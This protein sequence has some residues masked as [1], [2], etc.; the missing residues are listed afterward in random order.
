M[1][2]FEVP[3]PILNPPFEE[4]A[5]HWYIQEGQ[6]P[7][8]RPGRRPSIVFPPEEQNVP[9]DLADGTLAASHEYPGG[10]EL[11]LVNRVR[12]RLKTWREQGYPGATRT[13]LHLL[14]WWCRDGRETRLFFAQLEAAETVI[15]LTEARPDFL[16]GLIVPVDEVGETKTTEGYRSFAR[17][18]VQD[19][20]GLGQDDRYGHARGVEHPQ[21][22]SRPRKRALLRRRARRVPERDD[23]R[24]ACGTRS[25]ARR[26]EHLLH[27]RP[28]AARDACPTWPGAGC[29]SRTGTCSS[30]KLVQ[31]GGVSA[32][33]SKAGGRCGRA[34]PSPS[35][36]RRPWRAAGVTSRRRTTI[37]RSA[38]G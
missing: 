16:Q 22:G 17:R 23:P 18:R 35:V 36:Q 37:G 25:A 12:D 8:L 5:K 9:W 4:P 31:T 6:D 11:P 7:V 19:G 14:E 29:S 28:C 10:F 26:R 32:R 3:N 13:T 30:R 34:K 27:A 38:R 24:A 1:S 33:V 20:D 2:D 21:Q 15:F